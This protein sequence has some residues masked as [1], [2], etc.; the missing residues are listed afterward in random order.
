MSKKFKS[1]ASS[2]RA[3]ASTFGALGGFSSAFSSQGREPSSLTYVAEPP[4]LSRISEAQL[5][6]AFKNFLKKDEVTR[7]RALDDLRDHVSGVEN[8]GGTLDDGF[9]EA[10]IKIYPR[11]SIDLSRRVRQTAHATQGSIACLVG[12]RVARFL[13]KVIGAWLAGIYDNDRPVHLS[14]LESF[15]RVFTTDAKRSGVWKVYQSAILDFVDDVILQQTAQTL[16]DERTVKPDDAE[17][18][19][20][21]VAGTALLL[22]NRVLGHST[23]EDLQKDVATIE[24]LLGSKSLWALSYH[25]DPFVRKSLYILTRSA[26]SKEPEELDWKLISAALIGKALHSSQLGSASELSETILQV[27]SA[28]PQLWTGDYSG[29]SSASKRLLQYIQKGSQ[30]GASAFWPNLY[31]LL[32]TI[33]FETLEKIDLQSASGTTLGLSSA[34]KLTESFQEGLNSR[35]E[36]RQN[37]AVGWKAYIDTVVWLAGRLIEDDRVNFLR[38]RLSPLSLQHVKPEQDRPQWTLPVQSAEAICTDCVVA[39]SVPG[40][41]PVLTQLWTE[42]CDGLLE[43][44]KLSSPEQSKDFRSSQDAVCAQAG[45]LF[46]LEASLLS[47]LTDTDLEARIVDIC[48]NTN[49]PLLDN[50]LEVLRSRNGKPYGAAAVVEEIIR[51]VPQIAQGSQSLLSFVQDD[52]PELL[53]SPSADRLVSII[54]ACRSWD[55]YGSSFEKA[56]EH[57]AQS[58]PESSN[59]HAVQKLLSSLD[60]QELGDKSGLTSLI[61]RALDRACKGSDLHWSIVIAVLQNHTSHGELTDSIFLSI[62][63][64]LSEESKVFD[65]L[66]GLSRISASVPSA[67]RN[68]QSG[69]QGSKLSGKLLFLTESSD[70]EVAGLAESLSRTLKESVVSEASAKSSFEILQH[71]FENV[72]EESVSIGSLLG[73]AEELLQNVKP[74]DIGKVAKDILPSRQSWEDALGPFLE[75]PPRLSAAI[76]SPLAGTVHLVDRRVSGTFRE[77]YTRIPRDSNNCSSAFRLAYYTVKILSLFDLAG[78]LGVE[79]LETL[80][81]NVPL[82]VQLIDDD[83]SIQNCNGITGLTL[84]EQREE[85]MEIVSDGRK[86]INSWAQSQE[87]GQGETVASMLST[88]WKDQIEKRD[89]LSPLDYQIGVAFVKIM[90]SVDPSNKSRSSEEVTQ[91]CRDMRKANAIRSASW[92]AVLRPAILSNPAGTRLCNEFVADSTGLKPQEESKDGLRKLVLLNLLLSGEEDV[93]ASIPTQRLVFLTKHLIQCLQAEG[94]S[95]SVKAETFQTL[96]VMLPNLQEIYGSHWETCMD[97]LSTTWQETSGGDEALPALLSSFRLFARLQSLAGDEESNDDVKD[98]WSDRKTTLFNSLTSTLR[99]FDSSTT[100]HQ[101]RDVVVELLCRFLNVIPIDNLEDVSKF[102]P[103]L[104][105]QSPAVQRAAYT[106]LHRYIPSVQEQ[107]S[108]D[109]ALSKTTVGLPDELMSLLLEAPTM[110]AVNAAYGD[111]RLWAAVRSYLLSWKVVFDHFVNASLAVQENY[112]ASIKDN[113][114]LS[115]LLEFMFDF[116]QRSHGKMVDASKFDVRSFELDQ[117]E[118][119]ESEIQWLLVHLY[120]LCLRHLANMTK[121]WWLD[122]KKRIKGPVATWTEKFISPLVIGDSL[123]GVTEWISTQDPNEERALNVKIASKTAEIIASIPVDEDSPPVALSISLPPAYPLQP[124]LVVGRS[125]VLVDE[126]KWRSWL[127]TIQGVIMFANGNLVDGLL[128]FRK[129]VQGALKGQSEC[130]ICYSVISTDMQTPNKRCATCKNTF[131]SVCLFRWFKS[132]NQST[133]PLCRNNFVYV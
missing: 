128:A 17:A 76:T 130:A 5:G 40:Y 61:M 91:L 123:Q 4:D 98:A 88:Y 12:K 55:G 38:E 18:K 101:P 37:R 21:R 42:L 78:C 71:H 107:V 14:A 30:S 66:Q 120:F 73:I 119:P 45:R 3:A 97:I 126:K 28:R 39:L 20:A 56:V 74:E 57:V 52:A 47:R 50:C 70:E 2:S 106:V 105:A 27:T 63:D 29:K 26:V 36:P 117:S 11:A 69:T 33:P 32:Q 129:N 67:V 80:F 109:V 84:P 100:F 75:L 131:H 83:L 64:S 1:Q 7:T 8:R 68:F 34:V 89:A 77:R 72:N 6:I 59:A 31:Q 85:Y 79:E 103:L 24:N 132:S 125:R 15:T 110:E 62:V 44:V 115:P 10:W 116:L 60:F 19:Y 90:E 122:T 43:A 94:V 127:L 133:C 48:K 87:A 118:S 113:E 49:L 51:N 124:A 92:V 58:D 95:L 82:A 65:T 9:L 41:E 111:D 46:A 53:A 16:S 25:D 112:V 99:K 114:S 93:A 108:F 102:F 81:Y 86:V 23:H 104:T 13:P 35:D 96:A 121:G 22:F 54:M